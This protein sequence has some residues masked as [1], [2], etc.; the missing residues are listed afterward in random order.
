MTWSAIVVLA[1]GTYAMKAVGPV[2][3]GRREIS[4]R[5]FHAFLLIAAALLAALIALSTFTV[6]SDVNLD[7]PLIAGMAAAAAAVWR[8]APLVLVIV[9]AAAT[10]ALLRA[11][12]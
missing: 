11:V 12:A 6:G 5:I 2:V 1:V 8:K 7:W 4:P 3:I 10:T 9:I